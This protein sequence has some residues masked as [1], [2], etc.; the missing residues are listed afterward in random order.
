MVTRKKMQL[1][2]AVTEEKPT[3]AGEIACREI[4]IARDRGDMKAVF[5]VGRHT[6][7]AYVG[8]YANEILAA[9]KDWDLLMGM[10]FHEQK[11]VSHNAID[12]LARHKQFQHLGFLLVEIPHDRKEVLSY[13]EYKFGKHCEIEDLLEQGIAGRRPLKVSHKIGYFAMFSSGIISDYAFEFMRE[14]KAW[15]SV[16]DVVA[17]GSVGKAKRAI[18]LLAA[19]GQFKFMLYGAARRALVLS[20]HMKEDDPEFIDSVKEVVDH[21]LKVVKTAGKGDV[22]RACGDK[23]AT[24]YTE[25]VERE[26][27]KQDEK[28][29]IDEPGQLKEAVG[30]G[31]WVAVAKIGIYTK[32]EEVAMAAAKAIVAAKQWNFAVFLGLCTE[33]DEARAYVVEQVKGH[34]HE[35]GP[36]N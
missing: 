5:D 22:V 13:A 34:E 10:A 26:F 7:L 15:S 6:K 2:K 4:N 18:D 20:F 35:V 31:D 24:Y 9:A 21:A 23:T 25:A 30:K 3:L 12:R 1:E 16:D 33:S 19:E 28:G 8:M 17:A 36:H 11:S 27:G 14:A 29:G 32:S